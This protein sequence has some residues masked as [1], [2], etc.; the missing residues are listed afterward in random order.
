MQ[1]SSVSEQEA[2]DLAT[3]MSLTSTGLQLLYQFTLTKRIA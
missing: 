3:T 2:I 1:Y